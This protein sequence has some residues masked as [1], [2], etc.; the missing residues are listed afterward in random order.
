MPRLDRLIT[1][2]A[3]TTA[4]YAADLWAL[5]TAAAWLT[6]ASVA[7]DV[8]QV[9][10]FAFIDASGNVVSIWDSTARIGAARGAYRYTSARQALARQLVIVPP[11]AYSE[12]ATGAAFTSG[13]ATVSVSIDGGA[14][15]AVFEY[16][17]TS[18]ARRADGAYVFGLGALN[19]RIAAATFDVNTRMAIGPDATRRDPNAR[20]TLQ[21]D[22]SVAQTKAW[23]MLVETSSFEGG[24]LGEAVQNRR[25]RVR[26]TDAATLHSE[27][28]DDDGKWQIVGLEPD[29]RRRMLNIDCQQ[30]SYSSQQVSLNA[31]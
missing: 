7:A 26:Q 29:G 10:E 27:L 5:Q 17:L 4:T 13:K 24:V 2:S 16:P 30:Y 9:G 12:L 28:A 3:P 14:D 23:A 6:D 15:A 1:L 18:S 22:F 8:D 19:W 11:P 21:L 20:I 31:V 25:Y